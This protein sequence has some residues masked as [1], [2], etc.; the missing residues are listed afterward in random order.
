MKILLIFMLLSTQFVIGQ[1]E[2]KHISEFTGF[3]GAVELL[4]DV[5]TP[6]EFDAGYIDGAVNIDWLSEQFNQKMVHIDR[7]K[8]IYVYCK[9]GGRSLKSQERL[10]EL[11]FKNVVNL[12][13]GYDAFSKE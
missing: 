10:A 3:N 8:K 4:I 12:E 11:G 2:S 6:A 9:K 1:I 7:N 13:G 5:R